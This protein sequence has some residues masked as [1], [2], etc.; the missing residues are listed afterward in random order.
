MKRRGGR[1]LWL[2]YLDSTISRSRGRILPRKLAV[3]RPA[4]DEVAKALDKLGIRY[5]V[6]KEKRYPALWFDERA[7]GYFVVYADDVK[8]VARKIAEEIAK[9]RS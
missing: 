9:S 7:A 3:P 1:I 8:E 5:E 2:V 4:I 6:H